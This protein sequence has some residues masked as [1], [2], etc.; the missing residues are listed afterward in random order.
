VKPLPRVIALA[1]CMAAGQPSSVARAA[2]G[3]ELTAERREELTGQYQQAQEHYL[4]KRYTEALPLFERV[5]DE[6]DSPNAQLYVA[7]CQ[8]QLGRLVRAHAAMSKTVAM[9][10]TRAAS[11]SRFTATRDEATKELAELEQEVGRV[12]VR[13]VDAPAGTQV[14]IAGAAVALDQEVVVVPGE[15]RVDAMVPNRALHRQMVNVRAAT[16]VDVQ[17]ALPAVPAP[18]PAPVVSPMPTPQP[19]PVVP[20]SDRGWTEDGTVRTLGYVTAGLGVA[21]VV[22]FAVAG[23]M[24][25]S[26]FSDLEKTCGGPCT[27]PTLQDDIDGG[28]RLDLIANVG[29]GVGLGLSVAGALMI[30]LGGESDVPAVGAAWLPGGG[31][32]TLGGHF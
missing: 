3:A 16:V 6:L 4:A 17:I 27:D 28:R 22:T 30:A 15:V 11:E 13:L 7:R 1:V 5:A 20:P 19:T 31:V 29:L 25:N 2:E 14:E 32:A 12:I 23:T 8:R 24:A 21:G 18:A 10:T 26:R 9:A